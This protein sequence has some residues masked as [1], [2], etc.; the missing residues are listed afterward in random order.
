MINLGGNWLRPPSKP[1]T[2]QVS[3]SPEIKKNF[4]IIKIMCRYGV[5]IYYT[6]VQISDFIMIRK[7][8]S[9]LDIVTGHEGQ[10]SAALV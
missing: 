8:F 4:F 9:L 2:P 3:F 1:S 10:D 6:T 7:S 5:I